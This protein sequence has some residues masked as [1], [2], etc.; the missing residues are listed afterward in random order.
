[1]SHIVQ[2]KTEVRDRVAINAACVRNQLPTPSE[3]TARLFNSEASGVLVQLPGWKYPVVCNTQTGQLSYD[4]Y[5]G[6]W[7]DL[8]HLD[9]FLQSYA[10]E[11]TRLVARQKG[12]TVLEQPQQDGSIKLT[13]QVGGV[14]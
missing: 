2:I 8:Q 13:I 9:R 11:K 3:G 6:H 12:H 14:A 4:N 10:V 1:M 7:G 5:Q